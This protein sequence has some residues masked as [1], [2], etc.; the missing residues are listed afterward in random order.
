[1]STRNCS[2]GARAPPGA[3]NVAFGNDAQYRAAGRIPNEERPDVEAN[4]FRD[5][6]VSRS[7]RG[8]GVNI[9]TFLLQEVFQ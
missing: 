8:D 2:S 4:Q 7:I 9:I 5:Y 3:Q 1:M 6:I